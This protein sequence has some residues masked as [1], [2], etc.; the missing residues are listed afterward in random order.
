M[1]SLLTFH[2]KQ[3]ISFIKKKLLLVFILGSLAAHSALATPIPVTTIDSIASSCY[4]HSDSTCTTPGNKPGI[5]NVTF[6]SI[7]NTTAVASNSYTDY[8]CCRT[9]SVNKG[10]TYSISITTNHV[11]GEYIKVWI[12]YNSNGYFEPGEE[13][14][15]AFANHIFTGSITIPATITPN[16]KLRMRVT[17]GARADSLSSCYV[18]CGETEDY[19]IVM[20]DN[21]IPNGTDPIA[22][23]TKT[24]K[25]FG[26]YKEVKLTNTSKNA[27]SYWWN[28]GDATQPFSAV[29]VSHSYSTPGT[30]IITLAACKGSKCDTMKQ[31]VIVDAFP[32]PVPAC[33]F[34][35]YNGQ[36][37]ISNFQF[38]SLLTQ[39]V[40]AGYNNLI[41]KQIH[42][43]GAAKYTVSVVSNSRFYTT[44][45][46]LDCDNDGIFSQLECLRTEQGMSFPGGSFTVQIPS[47]AVQD[48]PLRMRVVN[49]FSP[50]VWSMCDGSFPHDFNEAQITDFTTFVHGFLPVTA[51]FTVDKPDDC[52]EHPVRFKN[53]SRN[54]DMYIWDFG[55]GTTSKEFEPEHEY[56]TPGTYTIKLKA[57]NGAYADSMRH[58]NYVTILQSLP[59]P[60]IKV[61]KNGLSTDA[62]ANSYQWFRYDTLITGATSPSYQPLWY[63]YYGLR[64]T[65]SNGCESLTRL[66][67]GPI[68][69]A[70]NPKNVTVPACEATEFY[71]ENLSKNTVSYTIL[72]GDG[73]SSA[74][75]EG[76]SNYPV[77][78]YTP[79]IYTVSLI[80]CNQFGFC[81]TLTKPNLIRVSAPLVKPQLSLKRVGNDYEL[82]ASSSDKNITYEWFDGNGWWY[83]ADSIIKPTVDR[84]YRVRTKW[85]D[86]VSPESS[87][88]SFYPLRVGFPKYDIALCGDTTYTA[89][90]TNTSANAITY[91]WNFG[92]GTTSTDQYGSHTYKPGIYTVSLKACSDTICDSIVQVHCVRIDDKP[93]RPKL[94]SPNKEIVLCAG[95]T[96]RVPMST[97]DIPGYHYKWYND[98]LPIDSASDQSTYMAVKVGY[99]RAYVT[100]T[101]GCSAFT[102]SVIVN[103]VPDCVWPGDAS[104]DEEVNNKDIVF[105]GLYYNQTGIA[106]AS[107]SNVY[108]AFYVDDWGIKGLMGDVKHVDC[109][110]D[111]VIDNN[112]TMAVNLNF[113]A[114]RVY[115]KPSAV[116]P[117]GVL[118]SLYLQTS[119]TSYRPGDWVTANVMIGNAANPVDVLYGLAFNIDYDINLVEEGTTSLT[120]TSSW[121]GNPGTNVLTYSKTDVT[122]GRV[123]GAAVRTTHDDKSGYGKIAELRF[124]L[125]PG[126]TQVKDLPFTLSSFAVESNADQVVVFPEPYTI[127]VNPV[128]SGAEEPTEQNSNIS[129]Y[130]NPFINST[131]ISYTL[132]KKSE[133]RIEIYNVMGQQI[134]TLVDSSQPVGTYSYEFHPK[135]KI[136]QEGIY[137]VKVLIDKKASVKRLIKLN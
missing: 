68:R 119:K 56:T 118:P 15:S 100:N 81:D 42:A 84:V 104:H 30:Y 83:A 34:T 62:I 24:E 72:W 82:H 70:F 66:G 127:K 105:I 61:L 103:A 106:R 41:C 3:R 13:Q 137:L 71:L 97:P 92:D 38:D 54:A 87:P 64:I 23:F 18:H 111:G 136:Y 50:E 10:N 57:Y 75:H 44:Q 63:A 124:Q 19:A 107:V 94:S 121:L 95:F 60:V 28:M 55:D 80:A 117:K 98:M 53:N 130:P 25:Y 110:G 49:D 59:A 35:I 67:Y 132:P 40:R 109:N 48:T 37:W 47:W 11:N 113:N 21:T 29:N 65:N 6:G 52:T 99:Y 8:S 69:V 116:I 31:S 27:T 26:C 33:Q 114:Q 76:V 7:N 123:Y 134:E 9:L 43:I 120:Y 133:V 39:S 88:I 90:F 5:S 20:I 4:V 14:A 108:T 46:Y 131:M 36:E 126:I 22:G 79:G 17:S 32:T 77:H 58:V 1:T 16:R 85:L 128:I 86:C 122:N 73:T 51:S 125:K 93:L 74:Y 101:L 96:I 135:E 45:V 129:L 78:K 89:H 91:L 2:S 12:D 115:S 112:D 102:D